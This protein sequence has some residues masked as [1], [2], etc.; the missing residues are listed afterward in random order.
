MEFQRK[1][2]MECHTPRLKLHAQRLSP[3]KVDKLCFQ[4]AQ[5]MLTP[6][7]ILHST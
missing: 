1:Q 2:Q 3:L 5:P 4:V 6:L 7:Q